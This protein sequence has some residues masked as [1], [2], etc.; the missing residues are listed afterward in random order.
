MVSVLGFTELAAIAA[1]GRDDIISDLNEVRRA[2]DRVKAIVRQLMLFARREH[3]ERTLLDVGDTVRELTRTLDELVGAKT[4]LQV[5]IAGTLPPV[6]GNGPQLE[7]VLVNLV[8]NARDATPDGGSI[9]VRVE[10]RSL[11]VR[12]TLGS[13]DLDAGDYVVLSVIDMGTGISESARSRLFEPFFTTKKFSAGTG[14]GLAVSH[15]IVREHGGAI[16]VSSTPGA[17]ATFDVWLPADI[18]VLVAP[19]PANMASDAHGRVP[20]APVPDTEPAHTTVNERPSRNATILLVDDDDGV[21]ATVRR[22]LEHAGYRVLVAKGGVDALALAERQYADIDLVL[23]DFKMPDLD[24]LALARELQA[25]HG[26]RPTVFMSGFAGYDPGSE[27]EIAAFG[28]LITK[29]V[30]GDTLHQTLHSALDAAQ[31]RVG[32]A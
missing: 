25:R 7:Q 30:S 15:G 26:T 21:R 16:V 18:S 10:P 6:N 12:T 9:T 19:A 2:G 13:V 14:L 8:V 32:A 29:P 5:E 11:P 3:V 28:P 4:T 24:G 31:P 27:E 17:G 22:Q 20:V 23:T 1:R